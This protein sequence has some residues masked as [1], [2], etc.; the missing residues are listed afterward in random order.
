MSEGKFSEELFT[1]CVNALQTEYVSKHNLVLR[2][3]PPVHSSLSLESLDTVLKRQGFRV[4]RRPKVY[5]TF[6]LDLSKPLEDLRRS[7]DAKWRSDLSRAERSDIVVTRT[8]NASDFDKF[9]P[10]LQQLQQRKGF[11]SARDVAFFRRV[12]TKAAQYEQLMVHLAWY[13]CQLIAGHIG[14]FAGDGAVYLLGAAGQLGRDL[15]ASYLLQWKV[16]EFAK[17]NGNLFY[18]LGGIDEVGNPQVYRFKKRINGRRATTVGGYDFAPS[19]FASRVLNLLEVLPKRRRVSKP[20]N[21]METS[22]C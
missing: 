22:K 1:A 5:E 21:Q 16:I 18:D 12:Q 8:A 2:I 4:V 10:L 11:D 13:N 7:V 20:V 14:S 3:D 6:L 17:S 15:R 9:E 19:K